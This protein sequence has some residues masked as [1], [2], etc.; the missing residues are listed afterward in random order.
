MTNTL[1]TIKVNDSLTLGEAFF[2]SYKPPKLVL[3]LDG[4]YADE[5][6][7][8]AMH[9]PERTVMTFQLERR[10]AGVKAVSTTVSGLRQTWNLR[11]PDLKI[12]PKFRA[13]VTSA[14]EPALHFE[15]TLLDDVDLS[16]L[17]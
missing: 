7:T 1:Y 13:Q 11:E 9:V 15:L 4:R 12:F 16:E 8:L 10:T 2:I 6:R 17:E 14:N 3:R 5:I